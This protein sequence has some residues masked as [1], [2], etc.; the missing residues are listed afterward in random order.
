MTLTLKIANESFCRTPQ[1]IVMH[2]NTELGR[3]MFGGLENIWIYIDILTP[4]CDFDL[5]CNNPIFPQDALTYDSLS[6]NK[7]WLPKIQQFRR[8]SSQS[9]IL[10]IF[11]SLCFEPSQQMSPHYDLE[12][13][14]QFLFHMTLWLILLHHFTKFGNKMFCDSEDV[15]WTLALM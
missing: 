13:S 14:K 5:E 3:K 9:H 12:N 10:I 8:Y 1:L 6:S 11:V 15:I 2:R 7:V 4:H